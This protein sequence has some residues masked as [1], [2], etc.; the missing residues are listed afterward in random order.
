LN[1]HISVEI[2]PL[3]SQEPG[4]WV[5][6]VILSDTGK[7]LPGIT[8]ELTTLVRHADGLCMSP[9]SNFIKIC[10][11]DCD[12]IYVKKII[13][14]RIENRLCYGLLWLKSELLDDL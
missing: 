7:L 5:S 2:F 9:A 10:L 12:I 6:P 14:A 8:Q 3:I 4:R 11:L 13:Y 1:T